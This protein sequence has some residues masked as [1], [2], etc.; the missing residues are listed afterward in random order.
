[1]VGLDDAGD[2]VH[3]RALRGDDEVDA[4]GAG[5]LGEARDTRLDLGRRDHHVIGEL[6]DEGDDVVHPVGNHE[7]LGGGFDAGEGGLFAL[8][9]LVGL[10]RA[11]AAVEAGDVADVFLG[12]D[13]V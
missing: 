10:G 1:Q 12:E 9:G 6:V 5:E 8:G 13:L 2:D 11:L 3:R 7:I 4:G